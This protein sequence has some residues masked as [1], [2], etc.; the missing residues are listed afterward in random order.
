MQKSKKFFIDYFQDEDGIFTAVV[1]KIPGCIANGKSIEEAY[2]NIINA[3]DDCLEAR[4]ILKMDD[5]DVDIYEGKNYY[6]PSNIVANNNS[7][8]RV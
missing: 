3:I 1:K 4:S 6:S 7:N 2:T 8:L 5:Y